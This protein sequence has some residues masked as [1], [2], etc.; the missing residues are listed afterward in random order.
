M[1]NSSMAV[2]MGVF[3]LF[4]DCY[5]MQ[6]CNLLFRL[7]FLFWTFYPYVKDDCGPLV[8]ISLIMGAG[9][10]DFCCHPGG[11]NWDLFDLYRNCCGDWFE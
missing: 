2:L 3:G 11:K 7:D 1:K 6:G 8:F 5:L 10:K 4:M 9:L